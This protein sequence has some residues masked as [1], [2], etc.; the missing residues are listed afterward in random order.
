MA[1]IE[2]SINGDNSGINYRVVI[3]AQAG[4]QPILESPTKWDSTPDKGSPASRS[5]WS[6]WIPACAGM[7]AYE[8]FG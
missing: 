5:Y 6:N 2:V 3:P 4:I 1:V 7:T 8:L